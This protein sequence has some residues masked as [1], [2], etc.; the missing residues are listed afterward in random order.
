MSEQKIE[1]APAEH[2][3][4]LSPTASPLT[5]GRLEYQG[6]NVYTG[7]FL[8]RCSSCGADVAVNPMDVFSLQK[9]NNDTHHTH[10]VNGM[11]EETRRSNANVIWWVSVW[12]I[13]YFILIFA[14]VPVLTIMLS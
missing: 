12:W 1:W 5:I 6:Y 14:S 7:E 8:Y 13:L 3:G 9:N 4:I 11:T 10:R 2:R